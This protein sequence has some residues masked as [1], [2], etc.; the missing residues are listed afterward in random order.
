MKKIVIGTKG[1]FIDLDVLLTTR[2]LI[3][4]N[5]GGGKSYLIRRLVEQLFGKVQI[6]I[7]DPEGEFATLREKFD[8]VLVGK[9]GETSADPRSASLLAEKLLELNASAVCD[10]YELKHHDRHRWVKLF[11][12]SMINSPKRLWHPVVIIVDEAHVFAPEKG[13]GES[14]AYGAM[15][16][17]ATRGRKRG[18]CS[19]FATQRL[20]K[21]SKNVSAEL[22]NVL[23][24]STFQDI[25]RKRAAETLGVLKSE[26]RNFFNNIK[27]F[28]PGNFFALGRAISKELITIKVDNV[29]TSTPESGKYKFAPPPAPEKIKALL[30]N[31]SDL[32]KEAEE[33]AVTEITLKRKIADLEK[34]LKGKVIQSKVIE[35]IVEQKPSRKFNQLMEQVMKFIIEITTKNF[36]STVPK[37]ELEKAIGSAVKSAVLELKTKIENRGSEFDKMKKEATRLLNQMKVILESDIAV[38]AEVRHNEPFSVSTPVVPAARKVVASSSFVGEASVSKCERAILQVLATRNG[39]NTTRPQLGILSGYSSTS[40]SFSNSLS[41]LRTKNLIT[42][43]DPLSITEDG[44]FIVGDYEEMPIGKDLQNYWYS[45]LGKAEQTILKVLIDAGG[46]FL[47]KD[48][49]GERSGYSSASGSF[50]NSLSKLRTLQLIDGSKIIKAADTFFE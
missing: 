14:E 8:F 45:K 33:K 1:E 46:E 17:L 3:Q 31:L 18:F 12:E 32:P 50:S 44:L 13:Q 16:D 5:S 27:L 29:Q 41:S 26:E 7:I 19:V 35:K 10:I 38:K 39:K 21:L 28:E 4:A 34:E 43:S 15:A 20:G 36:D 6:I 25:D 11:L 37:E 23:I 48:V 22:Q 49:I 2:L 40:G 9:G 47:N 42:G 24:G 30:P